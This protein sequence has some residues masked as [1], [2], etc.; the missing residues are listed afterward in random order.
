[1]AFT[2]YSLP[3]ITGKIRPPNPLARNTI[4]IN[5]TEITK[6]RLS[7]CRLNGMSAHWISAQ[8]NRLGDS[9][10]SESR[11]GG[12][13]PENDSLRAQV[14]TITGD[15]DE[16]QRQA[17][18]DHDAV[19][20]LEWRSMRNNL[21]F[22]GIHDRQAASDHD[23]VVQLEHEGQPCVLRDRRDQ[24]RKLRRRVGTVFHR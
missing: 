12:M 5:L 2:G 13:T 18:S 19:V 7:G 3:P 22:Y 23:A 17:A 21:V 14:T 15:T 24:G 11:L 1:M 20:Q 10:L 8:W 6:C 9:R 4:H 16:R